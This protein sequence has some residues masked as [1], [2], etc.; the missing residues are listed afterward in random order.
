MKIK[1]GLLLKD[2]A[3]NH[4]V[5]ACDPSIEFNRILSLNSTGAF[6]WSILEKGATK[7]ELKDRLV[8]EYDIPEEKALSDLDIFL[9]RL[10]D[11][12]V[13]E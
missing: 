8:S 5:V 11:Y 12:G 10:E 3:G 4:I 2:V 9:K 13:V 1:S 6:I 7:D